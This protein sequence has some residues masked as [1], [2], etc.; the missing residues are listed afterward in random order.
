MKKIT[1]TILLFP[2][3]LMNACSGVAPATQ[4]AAPINN[5]PLT[6]CRD[7][8]RCNTAR[9]AGNN[10][11]AEQPAAVPP[12]ATQESVQTDPAH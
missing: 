10:A 2:T 1:L 12:A 11:P 7:A 8:A 3:L 5:A 6:I 9:S 4:P